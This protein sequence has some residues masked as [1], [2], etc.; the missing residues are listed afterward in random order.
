[1][2]DLTEE[3]SQHRLDE[4]RAQGKTVQ[5]RELTSTIA[6]LG[7]ML[8]IYFMS[9]NFV[10]EISG[11]MKDIFS[12]NLLHP[13]AL[14]SFDAFT[15]AGSKCLRV[16]AIGVL[17]VVGASLVLGVLTSLVQSGF[18]FSTEVLSPDFS[19]V[20]PIAGF[21]R[22]FSLQSV[23][24]AFKSTLKTCVVAG[25]VYSALKTQLFII[26]NTVGM[27]TAQLM[28][29]LGAT[30][31]RIFG[32]VGI[33]LLATSGFDYWV[34]WRRFRQQAMMTKAEAKQEHKEREGDPQIKARIRAIQRER[35]RK[36]MMKAVPT[37]DVIITN[38]T[39][40]A[41]AIVYD[42]SISFAPRV[43]AK[44]G[45]YLAERIK[46]IGR[47]NGIPTVENK[48]LARTLYKHVKV[49]QMIPR[50]LYQAVAEILAYVFKL[51]GK[52]LQPSTNPQ[53]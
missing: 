53:G 6:L 31:M 36:R 11:L 16:F 43:V 39:H 21:M 23:M 20:D 9:S 3:P 7:V 45:D 50:S 14:D 18:N 30:T 29:F 41:V 32:V 27:G 52:R 49:G 2:D 22:L 13:M 15:D 44:G 38:P 34:Q 19:R 35:A 40:I 5:S 25:V 8:A 17:P 10:A 4:L 48:P 47:E 51:K 46:Q 33:L 37:A 12:K 1:M 24:E 42:P 28:A 26:P